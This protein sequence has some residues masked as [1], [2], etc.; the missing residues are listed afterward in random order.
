MLSD[1]YLVRNLDIHNEA[2]IKGDTKSAS[3]ACASIIAKVFRDNIMKEYDENIQ[4]TILL[5]M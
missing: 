1:G 2:V 5:I 3:I 4:I